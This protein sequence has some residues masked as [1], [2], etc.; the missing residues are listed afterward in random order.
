[1]SRQKA[2]RRKKHILFKR[3]LQELCFWNIAFGCSNTLL[4]NIFPCV[5]CILAEYRE[6]ELRLTH[7]LSNIRLIY[8]LE[9]FLFIPLDPCPVDFCESLHLS[10]EQTLLCGSHLIRKLGGCVIRLRVNLSTCMRL[11]HALLAHIQV[12]DLGLPKPDQFDFLDSMQGLSMLLS[13]TRKNFFCRLCT[14][15]KDSMSRLQT[16]TSNCTARQKYQELRPY[17]HI[18]T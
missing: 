13:R 14:R 6:E 8:R 17:P 11:H 9:D 10:K 18:C 16:C 12:S 7:T 1:M 2:L 3:H 5:C 4:L 15:T